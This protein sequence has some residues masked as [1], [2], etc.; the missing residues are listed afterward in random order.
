MAD[1]RYLTSTGTV[2]PVRADVV[3]EAAAAAAA[4]EAAEDVERVGV[5]VLVGD[6]AVGVLVGAGEAAFAVGVAVA[7]ALVGVLVG[8]GVAVLADWAS[9]LGEF[10]GRGVFGEDELP[11]A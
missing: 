6:A 4:A 7:G 9:A 3:G 10:D 2:G 5:E 11:C 8:V 1:G